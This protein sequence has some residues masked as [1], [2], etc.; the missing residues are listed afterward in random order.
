MIF[1]FSIVFFIMSFLN[2][3]M[4]VELT[5]KPI[6]KP[7]LA[8]WSAISILNSD[9]RDKLV[10]YY[11]GKIEENELNKILD[12]VIKTK[13]LICIENKCFGDENIKG[14]ETSLPFLTKE[15]RRINVKVIIS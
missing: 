1:V 5:F 10:D 14:E 13:Y 4:N 6:Y 9:V 2:I 15:N 11:L 12:R 7:Q 3:E 8:E